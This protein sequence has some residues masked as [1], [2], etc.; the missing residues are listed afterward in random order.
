MDT[1]T[2]DTCTPK[3]DLILLASLFLGELSVVVMSMAMYMKGDRSFEMFL[4]SNPGMMFVLATSV[5]LMAGA[6]NIYL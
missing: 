4:S 2:S 1:M 6:A 3:N 5:F